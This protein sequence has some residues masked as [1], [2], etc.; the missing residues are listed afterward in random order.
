M[1]QDLR[2]KMEPDLDIIKRTIGEQI[3]SML[4]KFSVGE[5]NEPTLLSYLMSWDKHVLGQIILMLIRFYLNKQAKKEGVTE[6]GIDFCQKFAQEHPEEAKQ[7]LKLDTLLNQYL[8]KLITGHQL[9][10]EAK[11]LPPAILASCL[12]PIVDVIRNL[13]YQTEE[14]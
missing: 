8:N 10:Q 9:R 11:E 14:V 13:L 5:I 4:R 3:D 2:A 6:R 7:I 12:P 1:Q